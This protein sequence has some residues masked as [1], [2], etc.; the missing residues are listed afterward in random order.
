MVMVVT[1]ISILSHVFISGK[2]G[3][4]W[5]G[6]NTPVQVMPR[7]SK[8][9]YKENYLLKPQMSDVAATQ[10]RKEQ[11]P[12][13]IAVERQQ[14]K[15][16]AA[17]EKAFLEGEKMFGQNLSRRGWS[18]RTW[19]GREFGAPE[20]ATGGRVSFNVKI[21]QVQHKIVIIQTELLITYMFGKLVPV[22]FRLESRVRIIVGQLK[23]CLLT[24]YRIR[25]GYD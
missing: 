23:R 16:L 15:K 12:L 6:L 10:S 21:E 9:K 22:I 7:K 13:Q 1:T 3:K 8:K 25:H 24:C 14:S 4:T 18:G 19:R 2:F 17:W 5:P 11:L 20:T